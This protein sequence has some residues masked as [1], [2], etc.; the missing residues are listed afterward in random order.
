MKITRLRNKLLLSAVAISLL[1]ALAFM[2][3]VSWVINRQYLAQ[4]Q[5]LLSRASIIIRDHLDDRQQNLLGASRQLATQKNLGSTLWYLAQYARSGIDRETL[6]VTYQQLAKDTQRIGA[7]AK[8]SSIFIYDA[9][10]NLVSFALFDGS[11][12]R[13]GFVEHR[14]APVFR[15][16]TLRA[17]EEITRKNLHQE[18]SVTGIGFN[19]G[20]QL[21]QRETVRY[22]IVDGE[23]SIES[24]VPIIGA[25]FDPDTGNPEIKQLG[26]VMMVQPLDRDFVEHMSRM[27]DARIN[28]ITGPNC[29]SGVAATRPD[30]G[31]GALPPDAI[32]VSTPATT[33]FNETTVEGE[34]FYQSLIPLYT[35]SQLVG[36]V[37]AL[38]SKDVVRTNIREMMLILS[39]IAAAGLLF[40]FPFAWY[41]ANS[42]SRPLTVL[43]KLFRGVAS[44]RQDGAQRG[45][46]SQLENEKMRH[47]ELGNL[48]QSF[49]AMDN[50]VNQKI[51]QINEINASLEQK[52][53]ERTAALAASERESRTLIENSPDTISRYDRD[54]RRIFVNPAFA[55]LAEGGA[56]ALL[57]TTPKEYPGGS[58]ADIYEAKIREVFASGSNTLFEL[59]WNGKDNREICTHIR[60]TP[61]FDSSGAVRTVLAVGRDITELNDYRTELKR[62]GLAQTRF[63]AAAGHDLRQ[64]IHAQGLFL[65]VLSHT[66]LGKRQHKLLGHVRAACDATAEMINALLDF[67]RIEAGAIEPHVRA[68]HMQPLLNKIEREFEQQAD[69][70]G[71]SYRSRETNLV[72]HSDPMMVELILRNL[73]S[74]AIRYTERGGV[75]VVCRKRGNQAALEVWDTGIGISSEHQKVVFL[76]FHQLNNPERDRRKGMGLGLAIADGLA[77]TLGHDLSLFS[78]PQRGSV[79][80]LTLPVADIIPAHEHGLELHKT[81]TLN[82]RVLIVEDDEAVRAGM[83]HLLRDWGCECDA[84]ETIEEAL[85]LARAHAP[86]AVISDYRLRAQSTGL[87]AI[88]ALRSLLGE[89][90]PALLITGD[91]APDR[92]REAQTRGIPLLHKPVSPEQLYRG[93][94]MV[95]DTAQPPV[96]PDSIL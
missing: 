80:R 39:L 7:V 95:L 77:R 92:L 90:L 48:A 38:H 71:L 75:L 63:L 27:T 68:F 19:F 46:L 84:A 4:S 17:G 11:A 16:A 49:I 83:Q 91:T 89:S 30:T 21:P 24:H 33:L 6:L 20:A 96:K 87:E 54:C 76:E 8:A 74:N 26:L 9:S 64:P 28:I 42:I 37:A 67:S 36:T 51:R 32:A 93:L 3:A 56:A 50:A 40:I 10:G 60:L 25:A 34:D 65:D 82:A 66:E 18:K 29:C 45:E 73:V 59:K 86:D 58:N 78:K 47:D 12:T 41:F 62:K 88:A 22:T 70:K 72:V 57:G 55:E 52:I 1:L 79:F 13:L 53:A 23:L 2:L 14:P 44:D 94:V 81:Q 61:E 85:A 5:A 43:S 15:V 35:G 31:R 69:A